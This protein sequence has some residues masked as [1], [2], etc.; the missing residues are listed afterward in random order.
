MKLTKLTFIKTITA[1]LVAAAMGISYA[2]AAEKGIFTSESDV[3]FQDVIPGVVAFG[4]VTGDREKGAH[5]TFVRIP[6]G[7][8][9]PLHT[10]GDAYHAVVIDGI[11]ENPIPGDSNSKKRLTKGSY[12]YVPA[13]AKH[14]SKCASDSPTDCLTFFYQT[15]AFSFEVAE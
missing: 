14:V 1:A 15:T 7:K 12:Y 8:A 11:F 5:G 10:H 13:G 4:T 3:V 2:F 9:T 6:A